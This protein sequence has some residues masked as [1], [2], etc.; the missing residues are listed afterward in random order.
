[1]TATLRRPAARSATWVRVL[2]S[3]R[4]S[5]VI[6]LVAFALYLTPAVR[7]VQLNPDVVEYVDVAR[8]LLAGEG[9][10]LGVKAYHIGGTEVLHN[11][12]AERPPLFPL[13]VAGV[14]GLGLD[15]RAVQV[16]NA[17]LAALSVVLVAEIGL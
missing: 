16:M 3:V 6:G 15:L 12:L 14:L 10:R 5:I 1:M 2:A 4:P 7:V 13:M 9:F 17:A 8:R 11:G